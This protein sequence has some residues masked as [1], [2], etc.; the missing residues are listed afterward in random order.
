MENKLGPFPNRLKIHILK[1]KN[2]KYTMISLINNN[3]VYSKHTGRLDGDA[4]VNKC[5]L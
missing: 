4:L 1:K 3:V 2:V 5:L